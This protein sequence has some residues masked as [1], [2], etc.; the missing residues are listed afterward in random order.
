MRTR[1]EVELELSKPYTRT[2]D[3]EALTFELLLDIRDLLLRS[4]AD[5]G[6]QQTNPHPDQSRCTDR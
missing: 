1:E 2:T 3:R 5:A 4:N 6:S